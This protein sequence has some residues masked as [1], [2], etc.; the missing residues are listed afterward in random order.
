[1]AEVGRGVGLAV[2]EDDDDVVAAAGVGRLKMWDEEWEI[3]P[4]VDCCHC[5]NRSEYLGHGQS[6][7]RG[8]TEDMN[9]VGCIEASG[10]PGNWR[11]G[12]SRGGR[13]FAPWR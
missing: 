2:F 11:R 10:G 13:S 9:W 6:R 7:A 4:S 12:M 3:P 8:E 1:M 5:S